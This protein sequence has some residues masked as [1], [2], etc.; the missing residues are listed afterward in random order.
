MR[1]H[2]T[3][4]PG[5]TFL[6]HGS[7]GACA[8]S[9][10]EVQAELRARLEREPVQFMTRALE[11]LLDEARAVLAGVI[12]ADPDDLAFI[13]NATSGV[14]T[15][16]RSLRGLG[17]GDELLVTDHVY[18]A[19]WNTMARAAEETGARLVVASVPFPCAGPDEVV[20]AVM[21]RV[22]ERTVLALVEHVTSPTALV[23][24]L[25]RLV[26][27][28]QGRGVDVLVDGAHAPGMVEIDVTRLGAAYYVGNGHK[29]LC[30]PKGVAFLHV[31]RDRQ[32]R[33]HPLVTSHG[34]SSP[35][36]DRSR[37][38]LEFDWTG[39]DD[40]TPALC[41]PAALRFLG[42]LVEGGLA[43]LRARNH[44]AAVAARRALC[45]AL[46]VAA[47]CPDAMVG[48][49][50]AL[51]LPDGGVELGAELFEVHRIEVPV[52]HWPERPRRLIRISMHAY[53]RLDDVHRLADVLA[54]LA[55]A[56]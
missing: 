4:D 20:E 9:I 53:N 2:W 27:A 22:S 8:R 1:E 41:L 37:F 55:P 17:P 35:R 25:D 43:G 13:P 38:R 23:F 15:V 10:L 29:W 11:P 48:S 49:M 39:T 32:A 12:G 31:R 6:N 33:L 56:R 14:N 45:A 21:S 46:G 7:F 44:E 19:C 30:A 51:P 24:P 3:L 47:P 52:M 54:T 28:L 16:L 18:G 50:A 36:T 42:S 34:R 26:A 5:V 40:P